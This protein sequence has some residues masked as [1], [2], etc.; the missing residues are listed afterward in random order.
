MKSTKYRDADREAAQFGHKRAKLA[1]WWRPLSGTFAAGGVMVSW[2]L[3]GESLRLIRLENFFPWGTMLI[4]SMLCF[5]VPLAPLLIMISL[6][7]YW[8]RKMRRA[9][10]RR[11]H[12][13]TG[14]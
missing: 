5:V 6:D 8:D 12:A 13:A 4:V 11:H 2:L 10:Q 3:A 14:E 7:V 1:R 9:F